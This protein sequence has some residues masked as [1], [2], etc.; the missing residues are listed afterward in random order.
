MADAVVTVTGLAPLIKRLEA[1]KNPKPIRAALK[2]GGTH[3][4]SIMAKYPPASD[5]NNPNARRWYE[6]GKGPRWRV[7]DGSI[8]LRN[9][10]E[11][12]GRKWT[13]KVKGNYE[14]EIGNNTSYAPY[15]H[16]PEKQSWFHAARGWKTTETVAESEGRK[17]ADA[18]R[19]ELMK[20]LGEG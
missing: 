17:V 11:T 13:V 5:A 6:R 2:M 19:A 9:T 4:K 8:H 3:I 18:I 15:V 20:A 16:D 14:V 10:S 1:A 7:K 12:L